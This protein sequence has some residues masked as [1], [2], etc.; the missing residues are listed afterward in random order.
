MFI[1]SLTTDATSDSILAKK[2]RVGLDEFSEPTN[3]DLWTAVAILE[4]FLGPAFAT[5]VLKRVRATDDPFASI[6]DIAWACYLADYL[7]QLRNSPGF[8]SLTD[9]LTTR[10]PRAPFYDA[11]IASRFHRAG[12]GVFIREESGV[13]GDD[14]DFHATKA[15]RTINVEVTACDN[16]KFSRNNVLNVLRSKRKQIP[17]TDA[18]ALY[19]IVPLSW[20]TSLPKL[21]LHRQLA[22]VTCEFFRCSRAFNLVNYSWDSYIEVDEIRLFT[23]INF[24][25]IN[26]PARMPWPDLSFLKARPAIPKVLF[27]L[28]LQ[29]DDALIKAFLKGTSTQYSFST[30]VAKH[31][32]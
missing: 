14:F 26:K 13:K 17:N 32:T 9:R 30:F 31:A 10:D 6:A 15:G 2:I 18:A 19:C 16:P 23:E 21:E 3:R 8:A 27:D 29:R 28:A 4:H 22:S 7:F 1:P 20:S 11:R 25:V 12:F 5:D 24:P